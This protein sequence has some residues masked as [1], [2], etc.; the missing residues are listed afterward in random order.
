M[1]G[2]L[3][4]LRLAARMLL[5]Q[6]SFTALAAAVLALGIG[7]NATVF[8]LVNAVLLRPMA[9][10]QPE[11]LV[12]LYS[13][14]AD[15][16]RSSR[17]SYPD[18]VEYRDQARAFSGLA[19]V[20]LVPVALDAQGA[21]EQFLAELVSG[22]AFPVL[23]VRMALG[24]GLL[25]EDEAPGSPRAAL[26]GERLWRR[27]FGADPDV[28]G[29]AI[30]L[31][32]EAFTIAGVVDGRFRGTFA[33]AGVELWVP[34]RQVPGW[35]GAGVLEDRAGPAV[36]AIGRL[37]PGVDPQEA[38]AE[39]QTLASGL[40]AV[41]PENRGRSVEVGPATLLHGS[42]RRAAVGFFAA[43]LVL[44]A[45]VLLLACANLAGL[46]LAR[47]L[48]RRR[49]MAV[50]L[51]LGATRW[52]LVRQLLAESLL[53]CGLGGIAALLL[54]AWAS[55]LLAAFNPVPSVPL[56]FDLGLDGRVLG[57]TLCAALLS[58]VVLGLTPALQST[59]RDLAP[60]LKGEPGASIPG[61]PRSTLRGALLVVQVALSLVLLASAGLCL[62][63]LH[64]AAA[65]DPGFEPRN[66]LALD[67][68]LE[69]YGYAEAR[70]RRFYDQLL[71]RLAALPG[72]RSAALANLA[73]LDPA[74]PTRAVSI[75]G[76]APPAGRS[77]F[78]I[79]TNRVSPGYFKTL[80]IPLLSGRGFD[81]RDG[82]GAAAVVIVNQTLA[83]R[84]W[85]GRDPLGQSVALGE[86]GVPAQVVGVAREVKYRTLGEEPTPHLYVPFAQ[87]YSASMTVLV[88][89][90]SEPKPLLGAVRG[91]LA[92]LDI[93]VQGFFARTL[94]EHAAFT[95]L[96]A[97]LAAAMLG[98]FGLLGLLLASVGLYGAVSL[99][100]TQRTREIGIRMALGARRS[101]VLRLVVG[102]VLGLVAAGVGAGVATA[103]GVTRVLGGLLYGVSPADPATYA[104]VSAALAAAALLASLGPGRRATRVDP[105]IAIR[106]E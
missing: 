26:L 49:E 40:A 85:P 100:V 93:A 87:D 66:A 69:L 103:L 15:G 98:L 77:S 42:F 1:T 76:Y 23:G 21:S 22:N 16:Q 41:H 84:F 24:R 46:L 18:Y 58:A 45:L 92:A 73:P 10:E 75:E 52:R 28:I 19:A 55:G 90:G 74:T 97:R 101:D 38:R 80:D 12:R 104:A 89:T 71:E 53:L 17:L 60:A 65:L 27:S 62:R 59:R 86:A 64:N 6:P 94:E 105:L 48:E 54:A 106:H 78:S 95:L 2:V 61:R 96:P 47:A 39:L 63:S 36:Q 37:R 31:N 102:R 33:G 79:S 88:Q 5:R 82:A 29:S 4:D 70:G 91:E 81:E 68:D 8:G 11:R 44:V 99:S 7:A 43:L 56:Q 34:L 20:S 25:P 30:R 83:R 50:R 32:G 13:T 72:V 35:L 3:H 57:F 14:A 9:A 67:V 51:A